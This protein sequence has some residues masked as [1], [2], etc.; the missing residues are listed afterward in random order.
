MGPFLGVLVAAQVQ[1]WSGAVGDS[2][3]GTLDTRRA[4]SSSL[5]LA[6]PSQSQAHTRAFEGALPD[7]APPMG[8]IA[9]STGGRVDLVGSCAA[10]RETGLSGDRAP[11]AKDTRRT[12]AAVADPRLRALLGAIVPTDTPVYVRVADVPQ[13]LARAGESGDRAQLLLVGAG[14][15]RLPLPELNALAHRELAMRGA[16]RMLGD[17]WVRGAASKET[18][19]R[20]KRLL[21]AFGLAAVAATVV[22]HLRRRLGRDAAAWWSVVPAGVAATALGVV[23]AWWV[24][25]PVNSVAVPSP[26]TMMIVLGPAALL[27]LSTPVFGLRKAPPGLRRPEPRTGDDRA[28]V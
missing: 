2:T 11:C 3:Q 15:R 10:L 25:V 9:R 5:L 28:T 27:L 12:G 8:L 18:A 26:T 21:S 13:A 24:A 20:W 7:G 22:L 17:E 6:G 19:G 14:D 4:L 1:L 23:V 16:F